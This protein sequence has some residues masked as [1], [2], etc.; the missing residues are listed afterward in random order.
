MAALEEAGWVAR[1]VVAVAREVI[2]AVLDK[3][4]LTEQP[5]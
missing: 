4:E 5:V 2:P 3:S 1:L